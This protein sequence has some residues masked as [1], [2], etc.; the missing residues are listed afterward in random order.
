VRRS[1]L[2]GSLAALAL[3]LGPGTAEAAVG[4]VRMQTALEP[5][6]ILFGQQLHATFDVLVNTNVVDPAAV[7]TRARF[8][9]YVLVEAPSRQELG[10]GNVVRVRYTYRLACDSL[11]CTTGAKREHRLVFP[12][13]LVRYR[14][15]EGH[16]RTAR[17]AWPDLRLVS[18]AAT[19]QFRPRTATEAERGLPIAPLIELPADVSAPSPTYR[20]SPPA[21]A[22]ALGVAAL[23]AL[24]AAVWLVLPVVA[25]SR[26]KGRAA[27]E[28]TPLERAVAAVDASA[29]RA[30][31]SAEHREALALLARELRRLGRGEL[32]QP[33]RRLAWSEEAPTAADSRRLLTE[34]RAGG[35]GR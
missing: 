17:V 12:E 18:R 21:A 28:L 31:G 30:P 9:P 11:S 35:N 19:N 10:D 27:P 6:P 29:R 23:L 3:V 24:A 15:R 16:A 14:D 34:V 20:V 13:A 22:I 8:L 2:A 32:V 4:I 26:A 33:A 5:S 7:E 25:L 1:L